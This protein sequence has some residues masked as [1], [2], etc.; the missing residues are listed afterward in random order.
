MY[1]AQKSDSTSSA[2]IVT[3]ELV[4]QETK[5]LLSEL[6]TRIHRPPGDPE[7]NN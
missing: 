7:Q 5:G 6:I 2:E 4:K 3:N 1:R